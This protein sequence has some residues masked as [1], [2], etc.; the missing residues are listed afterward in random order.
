MKHPRAKGQALLELV[1]VLP[2]FAALL[3]AT[4]LWADLM[5]KKLDLIHLTRNLAVMLARNDQGRYRSPKDAENQMRLLARATSRL[6]DRRLSF[7]LAPLPPTLT[8]DADPETAEAL[9][10]PGVGGMLQSMLLG[11]RLQVS[12]R[13]EYRGL[14]GRALPR[15]IELKETVALKRDPWTNIGERLLHML[16]L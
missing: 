11:E 15:G 4:A 5:L 2:L 13:M 10:L 8:Q 1:I 9:R 7:H 14:L 6:D 3:M 12:Y 16:G